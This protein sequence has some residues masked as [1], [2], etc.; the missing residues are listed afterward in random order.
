M[1]RNPSEEE[2]EEVTIFPIFPTKV[3]LATDGSEEARLALQAATSLVN[4]TSSELHVVLVLPTDVGVPYP[5]EVLQ[6]PPLEQSKQRA[7]AFLDRQVELIRAEGA[8]VAG[9]HLRM[10]RPPE[11]ILRLS[12]EIIA[13]LIVVGNQ[14]LSGRF[15]R[16]KRFV[17]G[18]VSEN[19]T[20]YARCSVMVVRK[21]LYDRPST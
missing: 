9:S 12:E 4:S 14:G 8:A 18:S 11:E 6:R 3:L 15:S 19:V 13:G 5:A 7:Q 1:D 2:R 17:M 20:R 10:G 16:M 21:D